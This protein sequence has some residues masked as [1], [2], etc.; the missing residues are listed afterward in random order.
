[1]KHIEK[2]DSEF[3]EKNIYNEDD[4]EKLDKDL[5]KIFEDE[6]VRTARIVYEIQLPDGKST[7]FSKTINRD[8]LEIIHQDNNTVSG[9]M[10]DAAAASESSQFE[11]DDIVEINVE[12]F[13]DLLL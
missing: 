7:H 3:T 12:T 9:F 13:S 2:I 10:A 4:L 8:L 11:E 6:L 1:M 5:E